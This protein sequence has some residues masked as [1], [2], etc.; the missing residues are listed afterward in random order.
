MRARQYNVLPT[1]STM[2]H[3]LCMH[4]H[5]F[6][7]FEGVPNI[8]VHD[9]TKRMG[10]GGSLASFIF[11]AMPVILRGMPAPVPLLSEACKQYSPWQPNKHRDEISVDIV[12]GGAQYKRRRGEG[13][14]RAHAYHMVDRARVHERWR[15]K[16]EACKT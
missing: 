14:A 12:D 10:G 11:D 1:P 5:Q 2:I 15:T 3:S 13:G 7:I 16:Q 6:F 9:K 4:L 8:I